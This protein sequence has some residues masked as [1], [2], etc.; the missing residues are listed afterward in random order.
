MELRELG[1]TGVK[2]S[3]LCLGAMMFGAW[4]TLT[5][6]SRSGSSTVPST[7]ASTSSTPPTSTPQGESEEIVG[8]ALAGGRREDVVL[9]TKVHGSMG[10]DPNAQGN[11]R[12]WIIQ[13]V[14]NSLRRLRDRL[15]RPLP[16]RTAPDPSLRHRRDPRRPDRPGPRR[17]GPLHRQ[18]DLP[19]PPDRRG[20]VGGRE[21]RTGA[22]RLRAAAVLDPGPRASR[23][24]CCRRCSGTAWASSPGAHWPAAG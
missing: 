2:V 4:G 17:Q 7:P 10:E 8:K 19:R 21:A 16:D 9:A 22:V 23:P 1:R 15:D 12:R 13:E 20:P 5:T 11:S 14:E 24:T 6:T 18:L 3:A